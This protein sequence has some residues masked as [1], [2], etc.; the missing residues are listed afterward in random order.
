MK[1]E[2]DTMKT[3]IP[4]ILIR[5][6]LDAGKTTLINQMAADGRLGAG[7]L[8][9]LFCEEG[10]TA[11]DETAF[12]GGSV[13][14]VCLEEESQFERD[15]L[16]QLTELYTPSTVVIEC[17]AMWKTVEFEF[18]ENWKTTKRISVLAAPTLGLYLTNMRAFLGPMLSRCD[19]IF[20][21]R[22]RKLFTLS[23]FKASLRPLLDNISSVMIESPNGYYGLDAV[24]DMLPYKLDAETL[25]ITPEN[26]VFWF[27]D[28][29][30]HPDRYNGR[31]ISLE[32]DIKKT[33]FLNSGEFALGTIA[34]TCCEADM[35]FLGYL[36]HYEQIDS[37]PQYVHVQ[38]TALIQYRFQQS[39][40]AVM[41]YLEILHMTPLP[42]G[43]EKGGAL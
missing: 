29:Q 9:L 6:F 17:N 39:Y 5:G 37:F 24:D 19:Q 8:L 1:G 26:Y 14:A 38:A 12:H 13:T 18:P 36:A 28:C 40:H 15:F 2:T 20:I 34:V 41:P 32:A 7:R 35:S 25:H 31:K 21:N 27:Y 3:S 33:P 42:A 30:D 23:P 16:I 43:A 22:C 4:V 11:F 10:E